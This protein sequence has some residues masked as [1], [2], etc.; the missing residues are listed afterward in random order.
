[1]RA[2]NLWIKFFLFINDTWTKRGFE[3]FSSTRE[4][5][6]SAGQTV[7]NSHLWN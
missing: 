7:R 5:I 3:V 4:Y 6:E 2:T 1:M